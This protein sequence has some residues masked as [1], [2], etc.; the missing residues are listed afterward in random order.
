LVAVGVKALADHAELARSHRDPRVVADLAAVAS[1]W[2][3]TLTRAAAARPLH[4]R[5]GSCYEVQARAELSRLQGASDPSLWQHA[6][7]GWVALGAQY[8]EAY[9]R[10]RR[11]QALLSGESGR[12][13]ASRAEAASELAAAAALARRV[14]APPLVAGVEGLARR[15]HI[16]L[17]AEAPSNGPAAFGLTARELDVLTLLAGGRTNGEIGKA[18]CITTKTASTHVSAILRKLGVT[19]RVE[20][21]NLAHQHTTAPPDPSM[22]RVSSP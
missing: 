2:I 13:H 7:A 8:E 4:P 1:G 15:A 14:P 20:A 6:V 12:S 3:D 9:A 11:A 21:A 10:W 22:S 18:L 16:D 19:N 5:W 17:G